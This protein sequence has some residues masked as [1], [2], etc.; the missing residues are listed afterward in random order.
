MHSM[1]ARASELRTENGQPL[2]LAPKPLTAV[3]TPHK[4]SHPEGQL[5][6]H[7]VDYRSRPGNRRESIAQPQG[8]GIRWVRFA[9]LP[10]VQA[11]STGAS[12]RG[13]R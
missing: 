7:M 10:P 5:A 11:R 12:E 2:G 8:R 9:R 4:T 1:E 13:N 6:K 3:M